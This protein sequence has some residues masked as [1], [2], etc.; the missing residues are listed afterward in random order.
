MSTRLHS[1]SLTIFRSAFNGLEFSS[2][3]SRVWKPH[4]HMY[5]NR[6]KNRYTSRFRG[7]I[8]L[9]FSVCS[10]ECNFLHCLQWPTCR[11][12]MREIDVQIENIPSHVWEKFVSNKY[13]TCPCHMCILNICTCASTL[14]MYIYIKKK[15]RLDVKGLV[16]G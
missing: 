7:L 9:Y 1:V 2:R 6:T 3:F 8:L 14:Y 10:N 15:W 11:I 12:R 5:V 13:W 4:I 16:W